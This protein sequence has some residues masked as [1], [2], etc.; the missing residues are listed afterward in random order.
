MHQNSF[1]SGNSGEIFLGDLRV[2]SVGQWSLKEEGNV[3]HFIAKQYFLN[4]FWMSEVN[5][6]MTFTLKLMMGPVEFCFRGTLVNK[7]FQLGT[8]VKGRL[9]LR[10]FEKLE[11]LPA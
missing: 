10:S 8:L 6:D 3:L 5:L 9:Y 11:L 2:G 4:K 1:Y 7:N